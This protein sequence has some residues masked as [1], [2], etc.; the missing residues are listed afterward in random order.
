VELS[1]D[2]GGAQR[3]IGRRIGEHYPD[4]LPGDRIDPDD[5][6]RWL[7]VMRQMPCPTWRPDPADGA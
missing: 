7:L 3:E 6:P 4:L 5:P 2:A 1:G